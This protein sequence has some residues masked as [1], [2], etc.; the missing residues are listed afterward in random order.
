MFQGRRQ[1]KERGQ[2]VSDFDEEQSLFSRKVY[3]VVVREIDV[4]WDPE[5]GA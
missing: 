2:G 3:C 5:T 1:G 4:P